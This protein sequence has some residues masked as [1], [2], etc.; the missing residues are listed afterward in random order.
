MDDIRQRVYDAV[1][2]WSE[3]QFA[4]VLS[5]RAKAGYVSECLSASSEG[6]LDLSF[7]RLLQAVDPTHPKVYV[8]SVRS[9]H[10]GDGHASLDTI[11]HHHESPDSNTP[12]IVLYRHESFGSH[13]EAVSWKPSRGGTPLSTSFLHTLS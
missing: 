4:S 7:L 8:I 3:Q 13:F 5:G 2:L 6:Q 10:D 11:A 9:H 1:E 12:S